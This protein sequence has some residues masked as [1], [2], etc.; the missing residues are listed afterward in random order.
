MDIILIKIVLVTGLL[1][2][3]S[4]YVELLTEPVKILM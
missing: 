2:E 3:F 4:L 1:D